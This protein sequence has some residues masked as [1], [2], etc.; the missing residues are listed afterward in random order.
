MPEWPG[1]VDSGTAAAAGADEDKGGKFKCP[2][3]LELLG[4]ATG[5]EAGGAPIGVGKIV[6]TFGRRSGGFMDC[7]VDCSSTSSMTW[8]AILILPPPTNLECRLD[9]LL[10][11]GILGG[12]PP[13]KYIVSWNRVYWITRLVA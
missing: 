3:R 10:L 9:E 2:V 6:L 7:T 5:A 13:E 1:G 8:S 12:G 4:T 11:I